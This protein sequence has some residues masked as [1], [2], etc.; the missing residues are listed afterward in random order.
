MKGAS[1]KGFMS[2]ADAQMDVYGEASFGWAYWTY[3]NQ[4]RNWSLKD[5]IKDS[6]ISV[7]QKQDHLYGWQST[8]QS[9]RGV[10]ASH[11]A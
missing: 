8:K 2:F 5:M 9:V 3:K 11:E 1:D 4:Y 6:I 7:P 10:K